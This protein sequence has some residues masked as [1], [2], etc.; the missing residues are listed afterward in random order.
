MG[1][2]YVNHIGYGK[3]PKGPTMRMLGKHAKMRAELIKQR[4]DRE[5]INIHVA[6][7]KENQR[8]IELQNQIR[9]MDGLL[10]SIHPH[11]R[12]KLIEEKRIEGHRGKLHSQLDEHHRQTLDALK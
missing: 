2:L 5:P 12:H 1:K 9:C 11:C 10:M 6:A 8:Q 7:L 4:M 3:G